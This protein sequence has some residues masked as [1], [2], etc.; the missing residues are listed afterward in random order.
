MHVFCYASLEISVNYVAFSERKYLADFERLINITG[1]R[2]RCHWFSE[3]EENP[4]PSCNV[5]RKDKS[6][7]STDASFYHEL[8]LINIRK[9]SCRVVL[10]ICYGSIHFKSPITVDKYPTMVTFERYS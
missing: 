7:N 3:N 10:Y 6:R 4:L 8:L 5:S 2:L 9:L 1:S